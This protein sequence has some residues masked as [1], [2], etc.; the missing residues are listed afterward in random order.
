[1]LHRSANG[2]SGKAGT[3]TLSKTRGA[4]PELAWV[5]ARLP[6][7]R[8]G[9]DACSGALADNGLFPVGPIR[10]LSVGRCTDSAFG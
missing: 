3:D 2:I 4:A 1:M 8:A 6:D 5:F 10:M 9:H 7:Y